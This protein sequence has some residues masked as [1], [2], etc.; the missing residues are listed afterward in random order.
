VVS[1]SDL[2]SVG[3]SYAMTV[4]NIPTV[5]ANSALPGG[6]SATL[7]LTPG[8]DVVSFTIEIVNPCI[9]T[10]LNTI[11]FTEIDASSP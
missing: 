11:T 4:K 7:A 5:T 1:S 8:S 2:A 3:N 10:S 6:S 9:N